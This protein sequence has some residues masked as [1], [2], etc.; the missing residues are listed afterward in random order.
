MKKC[1]IYFF[2]LGENNFGANSYCQVKG[3]LKEWEKENLY[4]VTLY[5][6]K[7]HFG[8]LICNPILMRLISFS[9]ETN[10]NDRF[11]QRR[12]MYELKV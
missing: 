1:G 6:R 9:H 12:V 3:P 4:R 2:V 5:I 11:F 10:F 8:L 7:L